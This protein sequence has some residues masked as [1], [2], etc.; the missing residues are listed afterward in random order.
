MASHHF[1]L[2]TTRQVVCGG[3]DAGVPMGSNLHMKSPVLEIISISP[4]IP[5][6]V[7]TL[8]KQLLGCIFS[9]KLYRNIQYTFGNRCGFSGVFSPFGWIHGVEPPGS[10]SH[11]YLHEG[12]K[13]S[14]E[15]MKG[16]DSQL[17]LWSE[18]ILCSKAEMRHQQSLWM[19]PKLT[20]LV[21][22]QKRLL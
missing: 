3:A 22:K 7:S 14:L 6:T 16:T 19:G 20:E 18:S 1:I 15:A 13:G 2:T 11:K 17:R 4:R 8:G 10:Q 21:T 5:Y 9:G 12:W